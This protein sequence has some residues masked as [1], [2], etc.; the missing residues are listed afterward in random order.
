[1][2]AF[3][4]AA[5][6]ALDTLTSGDARTVVVN[7]AT[8]LTDMLELYANADVL[9]TPLNVTFAG[10][11]GED[12][13]GLTKEVFTSFW[14]EAYK[15]Y[16]IGENCLVPFLPL[17]RV[18]KEGQHFT[19]LGRV[20]SHMVQLTKSVPCM[21]AKSTYIQLAFGT[22]PDD[23]CLLQD[24]LAFVT[25][26]E[27][28]LLGKA[29]SSFGLCSARDRDLLLSFYCAHDM[30]TMPRASD[31]REQLLSIAYSIF[32]TK[33]T[34]LYAKMRL[35]IPASHQEVFWGH[36][37]IPDLNSLIVRQRPSQDHVVQSLVA[38]SEDLHPEEQRA[39]YFLQQ[40][41]LG[42]QLDELQQFLHFV[43]GSIDMPC[44]GIKVS[45]MVTGH[46]FVAHTCSNTLEVPVAFPSL[47]DFRRALRAILQSPYSYEFTLA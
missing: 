42:L 31:I 45:F 24:L 40:V 33:P 32:I 21:L 37:T 7:R 38:E 20:L 15:E 19:A 17:Y 1:M 43:T 22:P 11:I 29:M 14:Q 2:L 35:G 13:G 46:S 5:F 6:A 44:N 41:I 30:H 10:E 28:A 12:F 34:E 16:F 23:T 26:P 27:R 9:N 3:W 8:V 47:Q 18:R 36:L 4:F 25:T 39:L